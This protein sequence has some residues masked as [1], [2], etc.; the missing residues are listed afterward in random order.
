M[1]LGGAGGSV[2]CKRV[3]E[4]PSATPVQVATETGALVRPDGKKI[5]ISVGSGSNVAE[6]GLSNEHRRANILEVD[7]DGKN[8]RVYASGLRNPV[9]MAFAPDTQ[10]LW[11]AVNERDELGDELVPDYLTQVLPGAFYGWPFSYFGQ[12]RDERV[13]EPPPAGLGPARVPDV[14]LGAH[15]ASLG[16]AFEAGGVFPERY[17]KGAFVGQHGSWNRSSLAGYKVVFV[18]FAQG[19]PSGPPEDFLT[20]FVADAEKREVYG[21]PVGTAFQKD[22][23]LLVADDG[24]DI[25]WRVRPAAR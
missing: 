1:L 15:T 20:G 10:Q 5:Y 7:P 12:H 6:N 18:P 23:S 9:G 24:G 16:L 25:V 21:R 3:A 8:E 11:T 14:P 19:R 22:G 13:Q 2:G 4:T 17:R